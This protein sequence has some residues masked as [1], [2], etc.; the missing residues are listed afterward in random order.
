[1]LDPRKAPPKPAK[2]AAKGPKIAPPITC[3]T[4]A[5]IVAPAAPPAEQIGI[6]SWLWNVSSVIAI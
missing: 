6:N 3:P 4:V 1:M 5:P 2:I